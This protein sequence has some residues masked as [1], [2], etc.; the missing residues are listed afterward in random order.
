MNITTQWL[1][2]QDAIRRGWYIF[3]CE[4][5]Q[6]QGAFTTPG[7]PYRIQWYESATNNLDLAATWWEYNEQYNYG[8]SCKKSNLLVVDCDAPKDGGTDN[9][10]DQF[11]RLIKSSGAS[12]ED[13]TDTYQVWTPSGFLH[14]YY[15]WPEGVKASQRK[16]DKDLDVRCNGGPKA[17]GYVIGAGSVTSAGVYHVPE[18]ASPVRDCPAWLV[19]AVKVKPPKRRLDAPTAL[20][21]GTS[22]FFDEYSGL[23]NAVRSAADGNRNETLNW[24]AHQMAKDGCPENTIHHELWRPA[25]DAGLSEVEI[26]RTIHSAW[27]SAQ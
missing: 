13:T 10:I 24:A 15:N 6:K 26:T 16:L 22:T 5:G 9:G 4:P 20:E 3:P 18:V 27:R 1:W 11:E 17:G 8:I 14:L 7:G 21:K 23:R 2:A 12:W 19:D 25:L